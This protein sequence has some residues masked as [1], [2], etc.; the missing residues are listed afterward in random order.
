MCWTNVPRTS[1][2]S[3]DALRRP[4]VGAH[5]HVQ[6]PVAV[7]IAEVRERLGVEPARHERDGLPARTVAGGVA[8]PP[9]VSDHDVVVA[10]AVDVT[11]RAALLLALG[12]PPPLA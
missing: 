10:V 5:R 1:L 6:I 9:L 11:D 4:E 12:A 8:M 7:E 3:G 2:F